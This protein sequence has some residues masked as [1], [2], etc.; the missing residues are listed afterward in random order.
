M[1]RIFFLLPLLCACESTS[2]FVGPDTGLVSDADLAISM[3]VD[4]VGDTLVVDGE[5]NEDMLPMDQLIIDDGTTWGTLP[6]PPAGASIIWVFV[7]DSIDRAYADRELLWVG[8]FSYE[9]QT[10]TIAFDN[11]W[12]GPG[13][14][15]YDDGADG[16]EGPGTVAGDG[17]FGTVVYA[18]HNQPLTVEYGFRSPA[19]WMGPSPNGNVTLSPTSQTTLAP[20]AV[21]P[22]DGVNVKWIIDSDNLANKS[23]DPGFQEVVVRSNL[24]HWSPLPCELNSSSGNYE[25]DLMAHIGTGKRFAHLGLA[26]PGQKIRFHVDVGGE[27]YYE[28]N[29][30][31]A[32]GMYAQGSDDL[33]VA[34]QNNE[35]ILNLPINVATLTAPAADNSDLPSDYFGNPEAGV[36]E[37]PST[38]ISG[39]YYVP[40]SYDAH[41]K[42]P[43]LLALHGAYSSGQ[44]MIDVWKTLA[45]DRGLILV[46]PKSDGLSWDLSSVFAG[47]IAKEAPWLLDLVSYFE[48]H[49]NVDLDRIIVE[50]FSDGASMSLYMGLSHGDTFTHVMANSP[51]GM[52]KDYP[53]PN[54]PK[55]YITHGDKDEVLPVTNAR[56]MDETLTNLGY[57]VTYIEIPNDTHVFPTHLKIP[58]LDWVE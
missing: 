48:K 30:L 13:V 37:V 24:T 14:A 34:K 17:L 46:A 22:R 44:W 18:E 39:F 58:M 2:A 38:D 51:G 55:V 15:L 9:S 25:C 57:D 4:G 19:G 53:N 7:D 43:L 40:T 52:G 49:F 8:S 6:P 28:L 23:V 33:F 50:G 41:V 29:G 21:P 56:W 11:D 32:K 10:N 1:K 31:S 47:K 26:Q 5:T 12:S 3:D 16:H 35:L 27:G 42:R 45:E 20:F 54:K 36:F